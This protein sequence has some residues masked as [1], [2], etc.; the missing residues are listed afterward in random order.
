MPPSTPVL[1]AILKVDDLVNDQLGRPSRPQNL[2]LEGFGTD[3]TM[4]SVSKV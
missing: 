4:T 2:G 3:V 1:R